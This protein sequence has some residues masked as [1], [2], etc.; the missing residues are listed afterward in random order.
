MRVP[1]SSKTTSSEDLVLFPVRLAHTS[2]SN[3]KPTSFPIPGPEVAFDSSG[4]SA[5]AAPK[6]SAKPSSSV[7]AP[8]PSSSSVVAPAPSTSSVPEYPAE[9]PTTPE[10]PIED[11]P[12]EEEEP[13]EEAPVEVTSS[14]AAYVIHQTV[15]SLTNCACSPAPSSSKP[16]TPAPSQPVAPAPSKPETPSTPGS[17]ADYN[18]CMKA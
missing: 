14:A 6:P 16:A 3:P 8:K 4:G 17:F 10:V 15:S 11:A 9:E 5:P 2:Y 7:A 13:I 1:K 12:I 18:S